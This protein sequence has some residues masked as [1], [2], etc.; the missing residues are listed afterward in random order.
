MDDP[1]PEPS[2]MPT[3]EQAPPGEPT[4]LLTSVP[5]VGA[6]LILA[7]ALIVLLVLHTMARQLERKTRKRTEEALAK[8]NAETQQR[9]ET[10]PTQP[11]SPTHCANPAPTANSAPSSPGNV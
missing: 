5:W 2:H 1:T 4:S 3:T 10:T 11:P 6:A 9:T 7:T 8:Y